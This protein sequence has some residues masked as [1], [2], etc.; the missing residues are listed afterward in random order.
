LRTRTTTDEYGR[1]R[2]GDVIIGINGISVTTLEELFY[3]LEKEAIPFEP[4]LLSVNDHGAIKDIAVFVLYKI[5]TDVF[6]CLT[7]ICGNIV[8]SSKRM[9]KY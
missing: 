2:P 5:P 6:Y 8:R 7:C 4:I 3:H 9:K 1:I